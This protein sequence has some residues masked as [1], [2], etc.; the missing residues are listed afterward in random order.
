MTS[1]PQSLA[2][3]LFAVMLTLP[4]LC[5]ALPSEQPDYTLRTETDLVLVNVTVRDHSG[6]FVRGLKPEDFTVLEDNKPQKIVSFDVE[7]TDEVAP[8]DVAQAKP[9]AGDALA[10]AKGTLES[11]AGAEICRRSRGSRIRQRGRASEKKHAGRARE[12]GR[13]AFRKQIGRAHV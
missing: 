8:P 2:S 4:L 5:P 11:P 1:T 7:N 10:A 3:R 9:I 6:D 13:S 12:R